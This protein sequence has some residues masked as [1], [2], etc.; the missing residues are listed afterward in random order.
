[1]T[2][3]GVCLVVGIVVAVVVG[4][5]VGLAAGAVLWALAQVFL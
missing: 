4:S 5:P 2:E 1:M 3:E